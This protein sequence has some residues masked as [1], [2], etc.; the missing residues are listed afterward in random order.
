MKKITNLMVSLQPC[1]H[2]ISLSL[3][4]FSQLPNFPL[5]PSFP[6]IDYS[7]EELKEEFEKIKRELL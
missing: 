7:K 6:V 2:A 3:I 5:F 4:S 1:Y